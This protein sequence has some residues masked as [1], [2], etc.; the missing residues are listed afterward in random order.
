MQPTVAAYLSIRPTSVHMNTPGQRPVGRNGQ[1]GRIYQGK[2]LDKEMW[3]PESMG[4][5]WGLE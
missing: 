3:S 4:Y 2:S 5:L 1:M